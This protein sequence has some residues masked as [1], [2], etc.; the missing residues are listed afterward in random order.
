M[1]RLLYIAVLSLGLALGLVACGDDS[2]YDNG[3]SLPL[4]AFYVGGSQ[5]QVSRM[6]VQGIGAP[7]DSLLADSTTL[8]EIYLP[9]RAN[10]SS[11]SYVF[12]RWTG[13]DS[14]EIAVSD[15]II[16][17][18]DAIAFFHSTECGAMFNFQIKRVDYTHNGIDSIV[19]V[20]TAITNA[21]MTAMRIYFTD[22]EQ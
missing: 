8:S 14:I 17:T 6:S 12:T 11:S 15:T 1:N 3:S 5:Q 7:G 10:A 21:K 9:L 16:F 13:P 18:Y 19:M 4:A 2:C 22:L 20:N